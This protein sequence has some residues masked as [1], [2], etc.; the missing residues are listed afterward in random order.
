MRTLGPAD[1]A[2]G[3]MR[4]ERLVLLLPDNDAL[5]AVGGGP[6]VREWIMADELDFK[7]SRR[8]CANVGV[9]LLPLDVR[10]PKPNFSVQYRASDGLYDDDDDALP[11][12]SLPPP[13]DDDTAAASAMDREAVGFFVC[14][15]PEDRNDGCGCFVMWMVLLDILS[16]MMMLSRPQPVD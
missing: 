11:C 12:P 13:D 5:A 2:S 8:T 15:D 1:T 9:L 6:N 14:N 16:M 10:S 7:S 3:L 4:L